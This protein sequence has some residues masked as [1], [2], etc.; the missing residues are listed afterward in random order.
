MTNILGETQDGAKTT[1][2]DSKIQPESVIYDPDFLATL[3][4][5]FAATSG[6]GQSI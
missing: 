2:R 4:P 1:K 6:M 5:N 3:P